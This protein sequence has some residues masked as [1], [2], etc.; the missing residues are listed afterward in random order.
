METK[1]QEVPSPS[2]EED[3]AADFQ[4]T[5]TPANTYT[6]VGASEIDS[7]SDHSGSSSASETVATTSQAGQLRSTSDSPGQPRGTLLQPR[8]ASPP[9]EDSRTE[10]QKKKMARFDEH[11]LEVD[12][13]IRRIATD[14]SH[15]HSISPSNRHRQKTTAQPMPRA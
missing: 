4:P 5:M 10:K 12:S 7:E 11:S 14:P 8:S 1:K 2:G 13:A 6:S 15:L 9:L 3:L